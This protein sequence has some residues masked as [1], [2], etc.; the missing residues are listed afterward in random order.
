MMLLS[1]L[2]MIITNWSLI[3]RGK[4]AAGIEESHLTKK[5]GSAGWFHPDDSKPAEPLIHGYR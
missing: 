2:T 1:N 3:S 5:R 4:E